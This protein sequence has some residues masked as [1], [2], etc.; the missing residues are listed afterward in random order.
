MFLDF[1]SITSH[2]IDTQKKEE[3]RFNC[4]YCGDEGHHL[5]VNLKKQVFKCHHCQA[6]GKTNISAQNLQRASLVDIDEPTKPIVHQRIKLPPMV[7]DVMTKA[8]ARYLAQRGYTEGD[9]VRHG[10]YC[11]APS[12]IVYFGRII[13]PYKPGGGTATYFTARSYM[14]YLIPRYLNPP[15]NKN[16]VFLSPDGTDKDYETLWTPDTVMIVEGPLDMVKASRHG[17]AG[18]LLG[19]EISTVQVRIIASRF[20]KALVMLDQGLKEQYA[21]MRVAELLRPHMDVDVLD[22][23]KKDPGEMEPEDFEEVIS[24]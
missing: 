22:C 16:L 1:S 11:A 7:D 15:G 21:A 18:A 19:K 23:P 9:A 20:S 6:G 2:P 13:I 10:M 17:R 3:I 24:R 4:V 12:S 14:K 8:A 5:Y